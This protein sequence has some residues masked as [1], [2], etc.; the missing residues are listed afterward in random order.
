LPAVVEH[1]GDGWTRVPTDNE[2]TLAAYEQEAE[3]FRD[4]IPTEPNHQLIDLLDIAPGARVLELGSGTGRDALELE[5]RGFVV[6]RTDA[7][8]AF[9]EMMRAD[10]HPADLLNALTD[11]FGG[12]YDAVFADAVFLHFDRAQL[13]DVLRKAAQAAPVLAFSTTEGQ[14]EEWSSRYLDVPRLFVMWT[15]DALRDA[16][17]ATGWS[18]ERLERGAGKF[19][20]W[21]QVLAVRA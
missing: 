21:M 2:R 3:R 10:G 16:L 14:G 8:E 9:L 19:S 17:T 11:D 12:P 6:R 20:S 13:P 15:E 7:T 5:R 18:V 4:S 1:T